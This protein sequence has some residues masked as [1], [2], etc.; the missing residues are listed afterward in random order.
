MSDGR[1]PAGADVPWAPWNEPEIEYKEVEVTIS[2]TISK[3]TKITVP[4][5]KNIDS[6]ILK[7]AVKEQIVLPHEVEVIKAISNES[8]LDKRVI[9]DLSNWI[10]D[11]FEVVE[12]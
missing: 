8:A 7:E 12:E 4:D 11:D 6:S 2:L 3:T 10:V 1:I 5:I 9:E